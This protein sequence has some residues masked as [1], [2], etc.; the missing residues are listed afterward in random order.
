MYL[1]NRISSLVLHTFSP[2]YAPR[3]V[4]LE[5]SS[6]GPEDDELE[7]AFVVH[8]RLSIPSRPIQL[9]QPLAPEVKHVERPATRCLLDVD[10]RTA[11]RCCSF[12]G[13]QYYIRRPPLVDVCPGVVLPLA[14]SR[15]LLL[16][17]SL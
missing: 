14:N 11:P 9:E 1:P 5:R 10:A 7:A 15:M 2:A 12:D 4:R 16:P 3:E 6:A 17:S 13:G 8:V